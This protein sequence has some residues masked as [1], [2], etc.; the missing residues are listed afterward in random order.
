MQ[1]V[2][3]GLLAL[4][5]ATTTVHIDTV[6]L[7]PEF[8]GVGGCSAGTGPRLLVDYPEPARSTLLDFLFLPHHGASLDIIKLEIGGVGDST[9]GYM[10][11]G[12]IINP[13][14][15]SAVHPIPRS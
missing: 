9:T 8:D 11:D 13:H 7:G 12:A 6:A 10:H 1:C 3:A 4:A 5:S 2:V 14:H 15:S